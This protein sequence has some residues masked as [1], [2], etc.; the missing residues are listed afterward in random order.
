MSENI[1]RWKF[2]FD[3]GQVVYYIPTEISSAKYV[4]KIIE[5]NIKEVGM[6]FKIRYELN[7]TVYTDWVGASD[8]MEKNYE[9][10]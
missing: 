2:V 1:E 4:A 5:I 9:K 7:N 10:K 6:T 8:L 3:I